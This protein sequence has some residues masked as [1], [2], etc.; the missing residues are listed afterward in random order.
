[1][2]KLLFLLVLLITLPLFG[3]AQF[4]QGAGVEYNVYDDV[5]LLDPIVNKT[6]HMDKGDFVVLYQMRYELKNFEIMSLAEIYMNK[7]E[8]YTFQP[9]HSEYTFSIAYRFKKFKIQASHACY[10]PIIS[11]QD[12][13]RVRMTGAYTTIGIYFNMSPKSNH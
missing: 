9:T 8:S 13:Y 7:G 4:S 2:K 10:H 3:V 12:R 5:Q 1:M 11:D 6:I